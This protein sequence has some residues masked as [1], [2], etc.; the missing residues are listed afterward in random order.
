M[1]QLATAKP[2]SWSPARAASNVASPQRSPQVRPRRGA[3]RPKRRSSAAGERTTARTPASR[4]WLELAAGALPPK[5]ARRADDRPTGRS[6]R[7]PRERPCLSRANG[8]SGPTRPHHRHI[9]RPAQGPRR[10]PR[11]KGPPR[12]RGRGQRPAGPTPP[13]RRPAEH[14]T[15]LQGPRRRATRLAARSPPPTTCGRRDQSGAAV[16][17]SRRHWSGRRTPPRPAIPRTSCT[18]PCRG[19]GSAQ[20]RWVS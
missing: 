1:F 15:A 12:P 17:A 14:G 6:P 19:R 8:A 20:R 3:P 16:P 10:A 5:A 2:A 11:P 4:R 18:P 13:G 7:P 9:P